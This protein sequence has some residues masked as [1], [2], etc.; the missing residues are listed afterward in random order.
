MKTVPK[1]ARGAAFVDPEFRT[2]IRRISDAASHGT[3]KVIKP[4]YSTIQAW[5]ADESY[6]V[7]YHTD[8]SPDGHYLYD[9]KTYAFI[10]ALDI[11]PAD[12]E[13]VYWSPTAPSIL[14][15]TDITERRLYA[16][17]VKTDTATLVKDFSQAP[18]SCSDDITGGTDPMWTSW[19]GGTFGYACGR[20][21]GAK[22]FTYNRLTDA[23]GTIRVGNTG[24]NAPQPA[25]SGQL[26]FLNAN[27][28]A[29]Q[30]VDVNMKTLRTLD[31]ESD[32][33][34]TLGTADGVDTHFSVQFDSSPNGNLVAVNMANGSKR[35]IMGPSTGWLD[36]PARGTHISAVAYKNP[37]WMVLDVVG[38][39][40][41]Q[42]LLDSE[43][44][45]VNANTG[46][47][48]CRVGHHRSCGSSDNCGTQGYWAEPHA[49]ISPSGSRILFGSDWGGQAIV[50][51]YVIELPNYHP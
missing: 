49:T 33:H 47:S 31:I 5:N 30:V 11:R 44:V 9:G 35:V 28:S 24:G 41:G 38:E 20:G 3:V 12:L 50:D 10:K 4:V 29:A 16:F 27:D 40:D 48:I 51:T 1:P 36:Y 14:Y 22:M 25:P 23:I 19:D 18:V 37:G 32:A 6:L 7:L 34:A 46:G 15:Y 39:A 21:A 17:N 42:T 26:F 45:L 2:T 8:G 43:V 13:Q